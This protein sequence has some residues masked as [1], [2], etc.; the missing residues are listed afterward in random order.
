MSEFSKKI[1]EIEDKIK[2]LEIEKRSIIDSRSEFLKKT[3]IMS[4]FKSMRWQLPALYGAKHAREMVCELRPCQEFDNKK[5][6]QMQK[7]LGISWYHHQESFWNGKSTIVFDDNDRFLRF[8]TKRDL[9]EFV[10]ENSIDVDLSNLEHEIENIKIK[11][12]AFSNLKKEFE[13]LNVQKIK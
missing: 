6:D 12:E 7:I 10:R 2:Q 11:L 13:D 8:K 4:I 3:E 9:L 1:E 5:M